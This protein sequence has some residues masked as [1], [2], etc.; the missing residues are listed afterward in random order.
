MH[1]FTDH[2]RRVNESYCQHLTFACKTGARL[3]MYSV[4]AVM[5]GLFP[6]MFETYVSDHVIDLADDMIARRRPTKQR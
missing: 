1:Y 5:H 3:C 2:P 6:F 4:V